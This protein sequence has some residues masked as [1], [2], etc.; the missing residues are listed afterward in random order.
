MQ[1]ISFSHKA[2]YM[3]YHYDNFAIHLTKQSGEQ[4]K[5]FR[6]ILRQWSHGFAV[7]KERDKLASIAISSW[8][9]I[10]PVLGRISFL[11]ERKILLLQ[12]P[13]SYFLQ[14]RCPGGLEK[15]LN[16]NECQ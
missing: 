7:K 8:M 16:E 13:N 15:M 12:T 3:K 14:S 4:K 1:N 9:R 11:T 5:W 6:N 2:T 10:L